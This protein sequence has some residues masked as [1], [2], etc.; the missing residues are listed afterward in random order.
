[1]GQEWYEV[2]TDDTLD[3]DTDSPWAKIVIAANQGTSEIR[4]PNMTVAK[5]AST[6]FSQHLWYIS[7]ILVD[8]SLFDNRI[9]TDVKL[10]MVENL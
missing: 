6:T 10:M 9:G 8:L 7:D 2:A 3:A 4:Y 5:A 1:M